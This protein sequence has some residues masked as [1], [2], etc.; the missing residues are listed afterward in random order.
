MHKTPTD[1]AFTGAMPE[2]YETLMVPLIFEPYA[3]DLADRLARRSPRR[4]LEI[5]AGTVQMRGGAAKPPCL[6]S[7]TIA[8]R[9]W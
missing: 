7:A 6:T 3:I 5:A 2:M 9:S 4:V 1:V 8:A